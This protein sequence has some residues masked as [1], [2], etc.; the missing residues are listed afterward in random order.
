MAYDL[1]VRGRKSHEAAAN[2]LWPSATRSSVPTTRTRLGAGGA[3]GWPAPDPQQS[4]ATLS[5]R[6]A[7]GPF[8]LSADQRNGARG[9]VRLLGGSS[10]VTLFADASAEQQQGPPASAAGSDRPG[11]V[12][13]ES[14]QPV[15]GPVRSPKILAP[16][17]SRVHIVIPAKAGIQRG[18]ENWFRLRGNDEIGQLMS[19]MGRKPPRR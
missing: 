14:S 4:S 9:S 10:G 18:K 13:G 15:S 8:T 3:R 2:A 6:S 16:L 11:I 19:A 1:T 7:P 17:R 12:A 5:P